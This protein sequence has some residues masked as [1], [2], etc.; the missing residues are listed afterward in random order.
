VSTLRPLRAQGPGI[1]L[2]QTLRK[3]HPSTIEADFEDK[4]EG[5]V[6]AGDLGASWSLMGCAPYRKSSMGPR[7]LICPSNQHRVSD[8]SASHPLCVTMFLV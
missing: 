8:F 3:I 4:Q 7:A 1:S 6:K 5:L 2:D